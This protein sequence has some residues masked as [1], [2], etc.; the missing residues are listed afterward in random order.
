MKLTSEEAKRVIAFY[1]ESGES[2]T[3]TYRRFNAWALENQLQTRVSKKNVID[4]MKRFRKTA[5]LEKD[6]RRKHSMLNNPDM[7]LN[8]LGSIGMQRGKSIRICAE[9]NDLSIGTTHTIVR[10]VLKL[11]P[12]RLILV[13]AL[14]DYD[15]LVRVGAC[16]QLIPLLSPDRVTVFS[17][18]A[19]FRLD[20]YVNRWNCR[21][22]AHSR[23]DDLYVEQSQWAP[24]VT[25]WAALT[26]DHLFGPYF[27]PTTVTGDS[28]RAMITEIFLPDLISKYAST[29]HIWFQQ[30]GAPAHTATET[31]AVLY[32]HFQER[33]I[34]LGC[35]NEWPPRS[36]DLT[37][38][39]FY[40]WGAVQDLV[41]ESG[42]SFTNLADLSNA[43]IRA[44]NLLREQKMADVMTAVSAVPQRMQECIA[45][46]GSQ[47]QHR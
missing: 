44:F 35:E 38:C 9:E 24:Q 23:P 16:Q 36:P 18:E 19:S 25:V 6:E 42:K 7:V 22:W 32:E 37:P 31:K 40:L 10:R 17:D 2:P 4:T 33:V 1:F 27:F 30:D 47:L 45:L 29:N 3:A 21:I 46:A 34:S 41:Y 14:S 20:G 11:Y 5:L 28:Y 13:Q 15:K 8:V 26:T 12:Y 43:L 39:D